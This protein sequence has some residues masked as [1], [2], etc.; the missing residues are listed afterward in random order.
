ML[1]KL[2]TVSETLAFIVLVLCLMTASS[3][4]AQTQQCPNLSTATGQSGWMLVGG[5]GIGAPKL[6]VN[7]NPHPGWK[8][9]P[10][11]GSSWVSI[12][13]NQGGAGG[14]AA[15]YTYEYTFCLCKEGNHL[16]NLS[17]YADNG[18]TVYLNNTQI[19]TTTGSYNFNG[20]AKVVNYSW[21]GGG[22]NKVR[23]VVHNE[24]GPTGLNAVLKV[25]GATGSCCQARTSAPDAA[26][27]TVTGRVVDWR[28][29]PVRGVE[30]RAPGRAAVLTNSKGE[31]EIRDLV[32]TDRLA[33]SFSAPGFM[34]TTKIFRVGKSAGNGPTIV[35][36]PRAA[37]VQ[38]D[39]ARGGKVSFAR[40]GGL[41][42]AP[43]SLVDINGRPL[44]GRVMVSLTQL[45][46][47]DRAQLGT[48]AGDF[49]ARM[50]DKSI[51]MLESFGLFEIVVLDARGQRANLAR[52][53][54][55]RFDLPAPRNP[56]DRLPKR[57]G[58]FSFDTASGFWIEKGEAA[59]TDELVYSGTI[60][61]L[62]GA[63]WNSDNPY[64]VTCI[65]VKFVDVYSANTGPIANELVTA[66]GVNYNAIS[67]GFTNNDGLV[68]LL[69]KINSAIVI[70]AYPPFSSTPVGPIN[71][72]SPNIVSGAAD[73]GNPSLCPLITTVEYDARLL[74]P[75][76]NQVLT[77][78]S[79]YPG[80]TRLMPNLQRVVRENNHGPSSVSDGTN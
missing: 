56:R 32:E 7:V 21:A 47:S 19:F 67:Y 45:D 39:A 29:I 24:G 54:T 68:C 55:A 72:T 42:I 2:Y 60:D 78:W 17:F 79:R 10:L 69:V 22:T 30:V 37:P 27:G 70:N 33:V 23:I 12:D 28:N 52:G 65:T 44:R 50:A 31:F 20:A 9:P 64:Q 76:T 58:L 6:P 57:T 53:K 61:N 51:R 40:G 35:V 15:N 80:Y 14:P 34:N 26:T 5:P 48:M 41:T 18:A 49:K 38:L 1:R 25:T 16:L 59:L 13:A 77:A 36:W 8:N 75:D 63:L 66:T 62:D 71:V 11:P 43:N 46:V 3:A 73:C 74:R 4:V